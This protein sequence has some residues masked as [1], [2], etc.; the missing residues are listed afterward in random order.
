MNSK[1]KFQRFLIL[2]LISVSY[3][4]GGFYYGRSGYDF[5]IKR[6]PPQIKLVNK[7]PKNDDVDFSLFWD[8]WDLVSADYLNRP[9]DGQEML[10]GAISGMVSSL[11]DPYTAYLPP[12]LNE[13]VANDLNSTYQGIGAELG[14]R[15]NNLIIV[16]PLDGSP[17]KAAGVKPGDRILAIEGESAAGI[18]VT[19]AV[20]KIRGKAGT[21]STL[22]I[23]REGRDSFDVEIKRDIIKIES[24]T[25]ENEGEGTVYIR[26]SRFGQNTNREWDK[27]VREI[28]EGIGE[29]DAIVLDLRGNPGGYMLSAVH[30]ANEFFTGKPVVIQQEATGEEYSLNAD[31]KSAKFQKSPE[32]FILIDE[33]SASASEIL[34][35]ALE[36]HIDA[37]LVGEKSFGKGTIQ[38]AKD[39]SDGSGIHITTAK[40]LTP[41]KE[42]IHDKG[43]EPEIYIERT[44]E[45]WENGIDPQL[46]K[47]IELAKEI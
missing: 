37:T 35:A 47:A 46:E 16:S 44:L 43:I 13:A 12:E 9:V 25:W 29:L 38:D 21:I 24:V 31:R 5:E 20:V 42:W 14:K 23:G 30:I 19:E 40:W 36:Y 7:S 45:D 18:T 22:T 33:G 28:N 2:I 26:V 8:V 15:D 10:Y 34:A 17:A 1:A 27:V 4:Y 39:F 6:N 41:S 32:V 11:G 3:F